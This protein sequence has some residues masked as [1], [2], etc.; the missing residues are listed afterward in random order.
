M[1]DKYIF[2]L[3]GNNNMSNKYEAF[4]KI[5]TV[6]ISLRQKLEEINQRPTQE[7]NKKII[8]IYAKEIKRLEKIKQSL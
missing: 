5:D 4:R 6:L 3:K 1:F 8:K 7:Q 2:N